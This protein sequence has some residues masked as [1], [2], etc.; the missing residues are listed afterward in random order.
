MRTASAASAAVAA[1]TPLAEVAQYETA[2]A[3]FTKAARVIEHDTKLLVL[4]LAARF[5]LFEIQSVKSGVIWLEDVDAAALSSLYLFE[6]TEPLQQRDRRVEAMIFR[7]R[8]RMPRF[9]DDCRP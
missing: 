3:M 4:E 5:E 7:V 9:A 6:V 2:I 8:H 1:T